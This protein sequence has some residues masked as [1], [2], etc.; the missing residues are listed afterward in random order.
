MNKLAEEIDAVVNHH[1]RLE[2]P[3]PTAAELRKLRTIHRERTAAERARIGKAE[4]GLD[5][6]L[7]AVQ[8]GE[9]PIESLPLDLRTRLAKVVGSLPIEDDDL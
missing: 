4:K 5:D 2:F 8:R 9:V 6:F 7:K 1:F 3:I